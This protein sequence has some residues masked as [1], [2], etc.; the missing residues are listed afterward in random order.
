MSFSFLPL[1]VFLGDEAQFVCAH[2]LAELLFRHRGSRAGS[3]RRGGGGRRAK[4]L[5]GKQERG[6]QTIKTK[7]EERRERERAMMRCPSA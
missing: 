3:R 2:L 5:N 4:S 1:F 7:Y 6:D